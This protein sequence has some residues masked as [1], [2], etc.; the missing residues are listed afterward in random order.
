MAAWKGAVVLGAMLVAAFLGSCV[1]LPFAF[2]LLFVPG[3]R[4]VVHL[5][6][7]LCKKQ[8]ISLTAILLTTVG[9]V[10]VFVY[11]DKAEDER[12]LLFCNHRTRIDWMMLW[13]WLLN[14]PG[15]PL[16]K[17]KIVLREDLMKLP[18]FGWAMCWFRYVFLSRDWA[19]DQKELVRVTKYAAKHDERSVTM[20]FP[21]GTDLHTKAI[22]KSKEF[23]EKHD[24]PVLDQVLY[25]RVTGFLFML[26]QLRPMLDAVWDVTLL[27]NDYKDGIR[28]SEADLA[29][30]KFPKEIHVVLKRIPIAGFPAPSDAAAVEKTLQDSFIKKDALIKEF[31][32]NNKTLKSVKQSYTFA[33]TPV[34]YL[35]CALYW[36]LAGYLFTLLLASWFGTTLMCVAAGGYAAFP[37][38]V[39]KLIFSTGLK[40]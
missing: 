39:H 20:I 34:Q 8:W 21:E 28:T 7:D 31:Y 23:A 11:G 9:G 14:L 2:P 19:K 33:T 16:R 26:E 36:L 37:G 40:E 29:K 32:A 30:G 10:K 4:S 15:A 12:A 6:A 38:K 35:A 5:W 22:A 13:L 24:L 25:P 18:F 3:A 1:V 27:Y 17:L